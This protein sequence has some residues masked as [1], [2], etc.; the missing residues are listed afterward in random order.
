MTEL[1]RLSEPDLS[2][3]NALAA[4]GGSGLSREDLRAVCAAAAIKGAAKDF[5]DRVRLRGHAVA[6]MRVGYDRGAHIYSYVLAVA[7]PAS[8]A[9]PRSVTRIVT[10][11]L[12]L[13]ATPGARVSVAYVS[14][15]DG[16]RAGDGCGE[17]KR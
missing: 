16:A 14:C 15:L 2:V 11:V 4:A 6:A 5:L 8:A 7:E 9:S 1:S 12:G 17:I 10:D 3:L 13:G